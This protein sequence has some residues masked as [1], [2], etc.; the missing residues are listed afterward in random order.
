METPNR[1]KI[2]VYSQVADLYSNFLYT[3][4]TYG[5]II[6]S[7]VYLP[8]AE[9]SIKPADLGGVAG[10]LKYVAHNIYFKF[11]LDVH[12]IFGTDENAQKVAGMFR[13]APVYVHRT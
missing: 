6:I 3:A 10:G 9:K 13:S 7:E 2:E 1:V 4:K 11:A 8:V 5:K 12:N